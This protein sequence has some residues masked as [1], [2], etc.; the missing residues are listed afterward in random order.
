[1]SASRRA[2]CIQEI[3]VAVDAVKRTVEK[4]AE[5]YKDVF[6]YDAKEQV[7]RFVLGMAYG[8][9][10]DDLGKTMPEIHQ[11]LDEI[12]AENDALRAIAERTQ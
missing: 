4:I 11:I 8:A 10:H 9:F 6:N 7:A 3:I 5:K 1:M 12:K 2:D